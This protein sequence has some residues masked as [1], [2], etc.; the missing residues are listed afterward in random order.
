MGGLKDA[1]DE[2]VAHLR[3]LIG[4][5]RD[6]GAEAL[7]A[8]GDVGD[9]LDE[10]LVLLDGGGVSGGGRAGGNGVLAPGVGGNG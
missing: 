10:Q 5:L 8:T 9:N 7:L 6:R 1:S 2:N 4:K 3:G